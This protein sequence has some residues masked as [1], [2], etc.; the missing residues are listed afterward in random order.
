MR[1]RKVKHA[2]IRFPP[3]AN[4]QAEPVL[5]RWRRFLARFKRWP[6]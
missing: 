2:V 1:L 3:N 5:G 4:M 6:R